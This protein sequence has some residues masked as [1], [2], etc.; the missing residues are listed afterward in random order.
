MVR[1]AD[2]W[3][4]TRSSVCFDLGVGGVVEIVECRRRSSAG[5]P[6]FRSTPDLGAALQELLFAEPLLQPFP[7]AFSDW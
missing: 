2:A 7:A 3:S 1:A 5:K 6:A 4:T